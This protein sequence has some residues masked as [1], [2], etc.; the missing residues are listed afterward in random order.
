MKYR[1]GSFVTQSSEVGLKYAEYGC[2]GNQKYNKIPKL[3][4]SS[5]EKM[6]SCHSTPRRIVTGMITATYSAHYATG[7]LLVL[8]R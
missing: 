7:G 4:F 6:K 8:G 5:N 2:C 3:D 1:D